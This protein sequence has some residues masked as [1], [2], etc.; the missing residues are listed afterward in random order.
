MS[1]NKKRKNGDFLKNK[2]KDR[3]MIKR[4]LE[5][6]ILSSAWVQKVGMPL[7]RN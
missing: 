1:M 2:T 5:Q 3:L 4:D 6:E 7:S